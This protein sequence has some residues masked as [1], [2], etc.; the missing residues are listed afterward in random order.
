MKLLGDCID[1]DGWILEEFKN[2][3]VNCGRIIKRF[4]KTMATLS[5]KLG[6]S[7][8]AASSNKSEAAAIY[9]LIDNEKLTEEVI[10][11][12]H[13][14]STI[15]RISESGE[16]IILN[17]QD[18][19]EL[20]YTGHKK[21]VGLGEYGTE[22]NSKGLIVHSSIAVTTQGVSL[23]LLDQKI[24]ARDPAERGKSKDN[25]K[26]PIEEKES[27]KWIESMDRSN[28]NIP[29]RVLAVNV[30]DREGDIY[31]FFCDAIEK[32][33]VFLTRIVQNRKT[34]E[35]TKLFEEI[36]NEKAAGEV[37]VSIPRDTRKNIKQRTATLEIK[38]KKIRVKAPRNLAK[39][40]CKTEFLEYSIILARE[41]NPPQ[42]VEAIEWYLATNIDISGLE[43][44]YEKVKWYVQRW[45]IE[46][47]HYILK[48]GCEIEKL[49]EREAVR[50]K[51]LILMYSIIAIRILCITYFGRQNP[52]VS[53]ESFFE[54]EEWKVLY[55]IANKTSVSPTKAPTIKE[56]IYDLARI[57]GFLGNNKEA[58]PGVKVIWK[59]LRE[60]NTVLQYYKYLIPN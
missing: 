28:K 11:D 23:G 1:R 60:L 17:V 36:E 42:G 4:Q 34:V 13:R 58:E 16:K 51:K 55:C 45:K 43:E 3:A 57:G 6:E 24:W 9:R 20:N 18:T 53:C 27:Y 31:E 52:G 37:V 40:Y 10:L 41:I 19:T 38:H 32:G 2:L 14:K 26:R 49:Q 15:E 39:K 29:D 48:S 7:I 54:E 25:R 5:K 21:T 56:A 12:A 8:A 44:A 33:K 59:G 47:F 46:R 50:L 22:K 30:C 35:E